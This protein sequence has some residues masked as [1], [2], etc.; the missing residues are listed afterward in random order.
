MKFHGKKLR[1]IK[2]LCYYIQFHV[3]TGCIKKL[4]FKI[5]N[6][7]YMAKPLY[8]EKNYNVNYHVIKGG[9]IHVDVYVWKCCLWLV[10]E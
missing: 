6:L 2:L 10:H 3:I 4:K 1:T 9:F 7:K 5:L 8:N